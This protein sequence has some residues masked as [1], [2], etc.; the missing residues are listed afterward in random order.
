MRWLRGLADNADWGN[1]A[2]NI[3]LVGGAGAIVWGVADIHCGV[4]KIVF[5]VLMLA[6]AIIGGMR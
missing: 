5:G 1:W 3:A 2:I 6:A 4:A